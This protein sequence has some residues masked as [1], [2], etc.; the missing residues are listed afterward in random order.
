[1]KAKVGVAR[2]ETV[3]RQRAAAREQ[4]ETQRVE[5][6][7]PGLVLVLM[8]VAKPASLLL[9]LVVVKVTSMAGMTG[10]MMITT[11][12]EEQETARGKTPRENRR[13]EVI[14]RMNQEKVK[15]VRIDT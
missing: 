8:E 6:R 14:K 15:K 5:R 2:E 12:M 1:M 3:A 7:P 13:V 11:K 10:W 4:M 9:L